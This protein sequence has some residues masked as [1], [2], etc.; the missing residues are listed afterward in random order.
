MRRVGIVVA[1][2]VVAAVLVSAPPTEP[3]LADAGDQV[4]ICHLPNHDGDFVLLVS[5][6]YCAATLDGNI[7]I[8]GR[9]ACAHGHKAAFKAGTPGAALDCSFDNEDAVRNGPFY[10]GP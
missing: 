10:R 7:L 9:S 4:G 5:G 2:I 3:V 1:A 6:A 8:V